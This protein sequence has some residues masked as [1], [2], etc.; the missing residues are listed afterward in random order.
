MHI[1]VMIF[2]QRLKPLHLIMQS[3]NFNATLIYAQTLISIL[4]LRGYQNLTFPLRDAPTF[5]LSRTAMYL[6]A[7]TLAD[8]HVYFHELNS[9][10]SVS[11]AM[12]NTKLTYIGLIEIC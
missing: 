5:G 6:V 10:Y 8:F 4:Q 3:Q 9:F 7:N 11:Y 1:F 12:L 2:R